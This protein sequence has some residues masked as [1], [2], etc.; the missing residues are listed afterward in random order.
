VP[1]FEVRG[2]TFDD[3]TGATAG[4]F[5]N[6]HEGAE[7]DGQASGEVRYN[8]MLTPGSL[9]QV[10]NQD[11]MAAEIHLYRNTFV[12]DVLVMNADSDDGPFRFTRNVIVNES[13]EADHISIEGVSDPSVII[14]LD[15]LT[16]YPADGIVDG[17]GV[18]QGQFAMFLGSRGHQL[19]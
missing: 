6:M 16:G 13:D 9:A 5:G 14:A 2:C 15:N 1:R 18:L 12:G 3:N 10:V 7:G 19:Q 8:I 11:G 17:G 4:L